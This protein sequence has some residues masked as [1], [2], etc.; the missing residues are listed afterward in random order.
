MTTV[1]K[2]GKVAI[3]TEGFDNKSNVLNPNIGIT[4][5]GT[6]IERQPPTKQ[7]RNE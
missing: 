4:F 2:E 5:Q 1:A 3:A 7:S 6:V